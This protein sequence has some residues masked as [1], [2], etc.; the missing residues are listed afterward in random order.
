MTRRHR[1]G[2]WL[3]G[4]ITKPYVDNLVPISLWGPNANVGEALLM[5]LPQIDAMKEAHAN[6]DVSRSD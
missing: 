2:G 1:G 4:G 5:I 3:K 6:A